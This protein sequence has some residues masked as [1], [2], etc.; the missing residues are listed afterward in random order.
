MYAGTFT[1]AAGAPFQAV[2]V[3]ALGAQGEVLEFT[4]RYRLHH[5]HEGVA[6]G[7]HRMCSRGLCGIKDGVNLYCKA[8]KQHGGR[9]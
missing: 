8:V 3:R 1:A 6:Q 9:L 5:V 7:M 4:H 2:Q